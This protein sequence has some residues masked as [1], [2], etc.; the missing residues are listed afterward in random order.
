[1]IQPESNERAY[2]SIKIL[3]LIVF[4]AALAPVALIGWRELYVNFLEPNPPQIRVIEGP[5]GIGITPVNLVLELEDSESGLDEVVIRLKQKRDEKE[6]LRKKLNGKHVARIEVPFSGSESG[7]Q[8]GEVE[9]EIR[10]FDKSLW[11]TRGE[12]SF[13]LPVDYKKPY[14]EILSTQHNA[15][16]GGAQLIFYR[17]Q[18]EH[19]ALSGVKVDDHTY[20]GYP[21]RGLDKA[22]ENFPDVYAAFYA[23]PLAQGEQKRKIRLFAED[24]VGNGVTEKFYNKVAERRMRERVASM[25]E[26]AFLQFVSQVVQKNLPI[27]EKQAASIGQTLQFKTPENT[28]SR[29]VEE[30]QLIERRL[31]PINESQIE[32]ALKANRTDQLWDGAF[33][34]QSGVVRSGFGEVVTY[35]VNKSPIEKHLREAFVL[36][37]GAEGD[38]VYAANDGTIVFS[39]DLGVYGST[40][41]IDH[42]F[43]LASV[44]G[45]LGRMSAST[46][47]DVSAGHVLG[48]YGSSGLAERKQLFF[49]IRV[50]G[51]PVDPTEWLSK[52]WY[53]A[54]VNS[55]IEDVKRTL[56][57]P[58]YEAF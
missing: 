31:K 10:T 36:G 57:I 43:G 19:L 55:K 21:A 51:T 20:A 16:E 50:H 56:G 13:Q 38:N 34:P 6:I 18:D 58:V 4:L 1:M 48:T 3:L 35:Y 53:H 25:S 37:V 39:T 8:E 23:I 44:Y 41:I 7:L 17:V 54:H 46:G 22:F 12:K 15:R 29:A 32:G 47:Q 30:F 5:R 2:S 24:R 27:L 49:Q 28:L 45:S 52:S 14:L 11:S 40:I 42:G 26:G 9:L 33:L